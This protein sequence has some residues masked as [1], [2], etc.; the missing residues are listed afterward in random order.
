VGGEAGGGDRRPSTIYLGESVTY[1]DHVYSAAGE[2]APVSLIYFFRFKA[3]NIPYF[4]LSFALS[5][6]ERRLTVM[7]K[8]LVVSTTIH[9]LKIVRALVCTE[10]LTFKGTVSRIGY[11]FMSEG[12]KSL[13]SF[14]FSAL[15][16][17]IPNFLCFL[18][19]L[20]YSNYSV[21]IPL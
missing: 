13:L 5:E 7:N 2:G 21:T 11:F 12:F 20:S 3:K 8:L 9:D 10:R 14:G 16:N 17:Q 18:K 4:S 1:V 15:L 19:L 6:H